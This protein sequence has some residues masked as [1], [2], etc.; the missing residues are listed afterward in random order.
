MS[1][2]CNNFIIKPKVFQNCA[3]MY[4]MSVSFN[5]IEFQKYLRNM[6]MQENDIQS[7]TSIFMECDKYNAYG[8]LGADGMLTGDEVPTFQKTIAEKMSNLVEPLWNFV[9]SLA[10]P[11]DIGPSAKVPQMLQIQQ[12]ECHRT[13]QELQEYKAKFEQARNIL[14]NNAEEL[15]LTPEE[16]DY[17]KNRINF[18]SVSLGPARYDR[19]AD[20]VFFNTNDTNPPEV[21]GFVKIII[22]EITHGILRNTKYTQAQELACETRA[23]EIAKKLYDS[24]GDEEKET[25]NFHIYNNIS[26]S[27]LKDDT[28]I[29]NYLNN[30]IQNYNYLPKN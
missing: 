24:M 10:K 11:N 3:V 5:I 2:E 14:I 20:I 17:I 7:A 6:G 25:F 15:G 22:H 8:Q 27:D 4:V 9:C 12:V 18:E 16:T 13:Q 29:N 23:I 19:E 21:G 26:M 28:D 1:S 30:W